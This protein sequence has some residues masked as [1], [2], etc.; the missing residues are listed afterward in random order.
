MI[1]TNNFFKTFLH[2]ILIYGVLIG[3]LSFVEGFNVIR[4]FWLIFGIITYIL[5]LMKHQKMKLFVQIVS[6]LGLIGTILKFIS[7]LLSMKIEF[8]SIVDVS[9]YL[10]VYSYIIYGINKYTQLIKST[11]PR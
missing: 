5:V 10:L 3:L 9:I 6:V 4:F 11:N 7:I 8:L 1:I 2:I